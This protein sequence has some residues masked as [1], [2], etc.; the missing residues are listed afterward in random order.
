MKTGS[1]NV[2]CA[3]AAVIAVLAC[4]AVA[5]AATRADVSEVASLT[6][7]PSTPIVT[8]RAWVVS[9]TPPAPVIA[10]RAGQ[11]VVTVSSSPARSGGAI[12]AGDQSTSQCPERWTRCSVGLIVMVPR[13]VRP[14]RSVTGSWPKLRWSSACP[15]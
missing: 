4:C 6:R 10:A 1:K 15:R 7:L 3:F 8:C 13:P 9:G 12:V 14:S 5:P 11:V 2:G